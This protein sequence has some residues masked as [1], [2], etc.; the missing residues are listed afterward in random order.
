MYTMRAVSADDMPA[1]CCE[2]CFLMLA[3]FAD[4]HGTGSHEAAYMYVFSE[5]DQESFEKVEKRVYEVESQGGQGY[6]RD[7]LTGGG[8]GLRS[9][10]FHVFLL[11]WSMRSLVEG[12]CW[13]SRLETHNR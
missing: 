13:K 3:R 1:L 4:G 12:S 7:R 11:A 8:C 6:D 10:V 5:G 2:A 9:N